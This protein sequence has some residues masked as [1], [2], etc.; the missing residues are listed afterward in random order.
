M[1]SINIA[2]DILSNPIKRNFFNQSLHRWRLVESLRRDVE[3][4]KADIS[5]AGLQAQLRQAHGSR[6]N[7]EESVVP[8]TVPAEI[9]TFAQLGLR[10]YS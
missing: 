2:R 5:L 7:D 3:K 8:P 9:E 10:F 4:L 1:Q 6:G